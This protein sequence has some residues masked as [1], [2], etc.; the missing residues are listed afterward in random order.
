MAVIRITDLPENCSALLDELRARGFAVSTDG[1]AEG[2]A[3]DLE[4]S[5]Q[6]CSIEEALE[7]CGQAAG[8][9]VSVFVSPG[10]IEEAWRPL[11]ALPMIPQAAVPSSPAPVEAAIVTSAAEVFAPA[12]ENAIVMPAMAETPAQPLLQADTETAL[13][14]DVPA[15]VH[16]EL[17]HPVLA[18]VFTE[19]ATAAVQPGEDA[20]VSAQIREVLEQAAYAASET[21]AQPVPVSLAESVVT[22]PPQTPVQMEAIPLPASSVV[23]EPASPVIQE[24]IHENKEEPV[25]LA[26]SSITESVA[27]APA[28]NNDANEENFEPASDWPIW[29]PLA[30]PVFA[31]AENAEASISQSRPVAGSGLSRW[32]FD[33]RVF[34]KTAPVAACLALLVLFAMTMAHNVSP[35]PRNVAI[36]E[37]ESRQV[38]LVHAGKAHDARFEKV[39]AESTLA[40][41][42]L[43]ARHISPRHTSSVLPDGVSAASRREPMAPRKSGTARN[44]GQFVARDTVVRYPGKSPAKEAPARKPDDAGKRSDVRRYS[45]LPNAAR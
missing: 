35:L 42:T 22:E 31:S 9:P 40:P 1:E 26:Q 25:L 32:K 6:D 21:N 43:P 3:A 36:G 27:S 20:E 30:E 28:A 34:W 4:M 23:H 41:D 17:E 8:G 10:S 13:A 12:A 16:S 19:A 15:Q 11:A 37:E 24:H 14:A 44:D 18:E 39:S 38:P 2:R 7:M 33:E 45:D 5:V 29:N